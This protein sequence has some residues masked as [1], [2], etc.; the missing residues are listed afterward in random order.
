MQ[1]RKKESNN[2]ILSDIS[3]VLMNTHH[4]D[5]MDRTSNN[6]IDKAEM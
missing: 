3:L 1:R 6:G 5:I 2:K 4:L